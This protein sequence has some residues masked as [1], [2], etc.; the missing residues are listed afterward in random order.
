MSDRIER[1]RGLLSE[2][3]LVTNL[4]NV[5]YLSGFASSNAALLVPPVGPVRLFTD[6][7]YKTAAGSVEGVELTLTKRAVLGELADLLQGRIAFEAAAVPYAGWEVLRAGGLELVPT[8]GLVEGLR[9]VKDEDELETMR[10]ASA[11]GDR[12]FARFAEERIVGRTERELAWRFQQL[13]REEGGEGFSFET[14]VAAGPTG[15][16]PHAE[17]GERPVGTGELVVVDAGCIVGGY[18]SDCTRTFA[19]GTLPTELAEAYAVCAEAQL[20]GLEAIRSGVT[21]IEADAAARRVIEDT[22]FAGMFGH[23]LGHGVGLVV[24][25]APTLSTESK[26]TLAAGNVASCE[27]GIYIEGSGGVRIEDLVVVRDGEPELLT[28]FTK[29]LV[30]VS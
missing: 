3:L 19:T 10:R 4:T 22:D 28:D 23:G 1:L 16:K 21:G 11:V 6:F 2:P 8:Q 12:A 29:E 7:R 14:I 17:P 5:R 13:L 27:P 20:A 18:C 15:A 25:E 9:A 26:D 30:T 24:H